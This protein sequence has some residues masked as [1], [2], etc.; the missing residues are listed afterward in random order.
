MI[1]FISG[2]IGS[3][4]TTLAK[5]AAKKFNFF[6]FDA[7]TLKPKVYSKIK[8]F[9]ERLNQGQPVPPSIRANLYR[10]MLK[11]LKVISK[12]H[13]NVIVDETL[14][15]QQGRFALIKESTKIFKKSAVILVTAKYKNTIKRLTKHRKGHMLN[16]PIALHNAMEKVK[17]PFK[18]YDLILKNNYKINKSFKKLSDYIKTLIQ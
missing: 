13:I 4:K 12:K 10:E 6:Y 1:I 14:Y 8:N 3:G 7:D 2:N 18:K 17:K 15:T 11:K 9:Q 16:N 5:M